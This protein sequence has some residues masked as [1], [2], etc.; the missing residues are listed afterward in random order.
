MNVL[1][2]FPGLLSFVVSII[3]MV[4]LYKGNIVDKES[5]GFCD[6]VEEAHENFVVAH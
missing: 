6:S 4:N 1:H 2:L 5:P 3:H